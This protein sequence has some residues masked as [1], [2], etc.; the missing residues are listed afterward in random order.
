L[1]EIGVLRKFHPDL[2]V[3]EWTAS[4]FS[5]LRNARLNPTPEPGL[6]AQP[7]ER[8]Y[9]AVL[10]YRLPLESIEPLHQRL[11]LRRETQRL[12]LDVQW[13]RRNAAILGNPN[14]RPSEIVAVLDE[15]EPSAISLFD[16]LAADPTIHSSIDRYRSEWAMV[17]AELTGDDLRG[18]G[19]PRGPLYRDILSA[20]RRARLDG[21]AT[22]RD[23]ETAIA[24]RV[25]ADACAPS[26]A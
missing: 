25:A 24:L 22:S 19:I 8:Q 1:D 18:L 2:A 14:A 4:A 15:A 6:I 3:G 20:V 11:G 21:I 5:T 16:V 7:L 9:W 17:H 23:E 10:V 12:T 13:L 26:D